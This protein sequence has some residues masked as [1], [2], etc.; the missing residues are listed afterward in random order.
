MEKYRI[1]LVVALVLMSAF[2]GCGKDNTDRPLPAQ[3]FTVTFNSN[4]G[5]TIDSQFVTEGETITDPPAPTKAGY[6]F[7]GWFTDNGTF[8]NRVTFP[9]TVIS[10]ISLYAK[11]ATVVYTVTFDSNGGSAVDSQPVAEGGQA[12]EPKAPTKAGYI[13]AEWC[14]DNGTFAI[15]VTFP[16]SVTSDVTLYAKWFD[17]PDAGVWI[18]IR[19]PAQLNAVR[20]NPSGNYIL[21]NDISLAEY[22]N[23]VPIYGFKGKFDG[24]DHNI[25]ELA[26]IHA[27]TDF[28]GLFGYIGGGSVSNLGVEIAAG[29][30]NGGY[31]VGGIAGNVSNSTITNCYS[32]GNITATSS[33]SSYYSGGIAGYASNSVIINCYSTGNISS[34]SHSGGIAGFVWNNSE[35][36]NCHSMGT[37]TATATSK[38]GD[39]YSGGIAGYVSGS[40]TITGCYST[41]TITAT[42]IIYG[43]SC[44]GGIVGSVNDNS[45]ITNCYNTGNVPSSGPSGGIAGSVSHGTI[46]N[47][48]SAG[49][50][51]TSSGSGG[52]AG[53]VS[54]STITNSCST[55]D[56]TT[57]SG[58]AGG[59]AGGVSYGAITNCYSTG[60]ITT[61]SD[62][63]SG[64]IAGNAYISTITNCYSSGNIAVNGYGYSGGIVG[65][66]SYSRDITNC[67]AINPTIKSMYRAG[68]IF[69]SI[70]DT[71]GVQISNNFALS[72]MA[73]TGATFNAAGYGI[74][75]TDVELKMQT[76]YSDPINGDG[77]GGL[78]WK[79]GN[80]DDNPWKMPVGGGYPILYWQP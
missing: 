20:N 79:F 58:S 17:A 39:S 15:P 77:L 14:A 31:Y 27:T 50:I 56:I 57:S 47:C 42:A 28:V 13:F 40:N 80:D 68:R 33:Y 44:S 51:I 35:I 61:T 9:Y 45:T 72:N 10:D 76:T 30:V 25:T 54:F 60:N 48:Y 63:S 73:A 11:W 3:T 7:A 8:N 64:G 78:G 37:I 43:E 70:Q 12:V 38:Y 1:I 62:F 41:G 65:Y 55:G 24:N 21:M 67:A 32:M 4:G 26:I 74:S 36:T 75:K 23:W 52:I 53:D 5:S 69:G 66:G 16:Y 59:I 18:G 2:A 22:P 19:T 34:G 46:T 49:D 71:Y 6:T 29:G